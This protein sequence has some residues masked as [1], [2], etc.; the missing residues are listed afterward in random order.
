MTQYLVFHFSQIS[1]L[2]LIR[3]RIFYFITPNY[4]SVISLSCRLCTKTLW[5]AV[6]DKGDPV[7]LN[8]ILH[9]ELIF[10]AFFISVLL[11]LSYTVNWLK[12][13]GWFSNIVVLSHVTKYSKVFKELMQYNIC[14]KGAIEIWV[15]RNTLINPTSEKWH[16]LKGHHR[17]KQRVQQVFFLQDGKFQRN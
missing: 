9:E 17:E 14:E 13:L 15:V 8:L 3:K 2:I 16:Y 1:L 10:P 11:C 7:I 4:E 6:T 12:T 5:I